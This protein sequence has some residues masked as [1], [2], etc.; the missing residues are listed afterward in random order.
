[1][2]VKSVQL[3]LLCVVRQYVSDWLALVSNAACADKPD[4]I[5]HNAVSAIRMAAPSVVNIARGRC[6][7][8][9]GWNVLALRSG[10]CH[11][12]SV[13]LF[14]AFANWKCRWRRYIFSCPIDLFVAPC[15]AGVPHSPF[16]PFLSMHF[17]ILL[18][19]TFPFFICFTYFLLLSIFSLSTRI[20]PL[21]CQA[22]GRRGDWTWV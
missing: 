6:R 18:L 7:A 10:L 4:H 11:V 2:R 21:C 19:F 17:I 13:D 1:M 3:S 15:G 9:D 8:D 20:A 14:Y 16:F 22:G 5:R 12:Q